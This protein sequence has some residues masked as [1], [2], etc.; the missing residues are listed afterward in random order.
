MCL[1]G[2]KQCLV[3]TVMSFLGVAL[4]NQ[5]EKLLLSAFYADRVQDLK[6][7]SPFQERAAQGPSHSPHTPPILFSPG[8]GHGNPLQYSC[9]ENP[10][11]RGAWWAMVQRVAKSRT[12]LSK[13]YILHLRG[14][15][16]FRVESECGFPGVKHSSYKWPG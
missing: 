4:L 2:E 13:Y 12:R 11:D 16:H 5:K 6:R 1:L 7:T 8:G 15:Q 3:N 14:S 9:L 10:M